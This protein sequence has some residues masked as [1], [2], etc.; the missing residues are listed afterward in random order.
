MDDQDVSLTL[1]V[2]E[3]NGLSRDQIAAF[4]ERM[5]ERREDIRTLLID[6]G[7][8]FP[9]LSVTLPGVYQ[10]TSYNVATRKTQ[11]RD[12]PQSHA[13]M[14]FSNVVTSYTH[15]RD[16][17]EDPLPLGEE[18]RLATQGWLAKLEEKLSSVQQES[19]VTPIEHEASQNSFEGYVFPEA[20]QA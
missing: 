9:H 14:Y 19:A 20:A 2:A 8:A 17:A 3:A 11:K 10:K 6:Q 13:S 15:I 16:N 1:N 5:L 4:V 18:M 12:V 7:G